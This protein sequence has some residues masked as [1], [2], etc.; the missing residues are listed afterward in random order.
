MLQQNIES[1][2]FFLLVVFTGG[3]LHAHA[4]VCY[5]TIGLQHEVVIV[6]ESPADICT[7]G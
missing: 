7:Q 1:S 6:A 2:F 5:S 3:R 4:N